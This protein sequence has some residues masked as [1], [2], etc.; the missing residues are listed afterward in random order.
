MCFRCADRRKL[1]RIPKSTGKDW[2]LRLR[3]CLCQHS[4]G[5]LPALCPGKDQR[6]LDPLPAAKR[7]KTL[8][9][10]VEIWT[11]GK[12]VAR[13]EPCYRKREQVLD[14]EHYLDVLERKLS[15]LAGSTPLAQWRSQGRWP[16][17][18]DLLWQ[19]LIE[20]LGGQN[21]SREMIA[22]LHLGRS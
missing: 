14:L 2:R 9:G 10:H 17:S 16:K 5:G 1:F 18:Y 12:C 19:R 22:L 21:G 4:S 13:H 15:A 7:W 3:S 20:R 8:L 11:R 6:L